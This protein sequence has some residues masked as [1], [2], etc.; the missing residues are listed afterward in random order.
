[1]KP[2][3]KSP[4]VYTTIG[5]GKD[6]FGREQFQSTLAITRMTPKV[7]TG[8]NCR[9]K[10]GAEISAAMAFFEDE[11]NQE[12]LENLEPSN[13]VHVS[14]SK[15]RLKLLWARKAAQ[16]QADQAR[17][18]GQGSAP[19]SSAGKCPPTSG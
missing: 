18:S 7:Y 13:R 15:A 19:E 4:A 6:D 12:L 8:V 1:M 3:E 10:K 9:T 17:S 14:L 16:A 2:G 5:L 11:I